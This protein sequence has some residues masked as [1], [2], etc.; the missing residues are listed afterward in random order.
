M[1]DDDGS[2][3]DS[4]S[5]PPAVNIAL[6]RAIDFVWRLGAEYP[7]TQLVPA[8][9]HAR[10]YMLQFV[11]LWTSSVLPAVISG[12]KVNE[13]DLVTLAKWLKWQRHANQR[14]GPFWLG[15]R[16]ALP[17]VVVA[18]FV[19]ELLFDGR[20]PDS[21][22]CAALAAWLAAIQASLLIVA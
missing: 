20:M 5:L 12:T 10:I 7:E 19:D 17:E 13:N 21:P 4:F 16:I 18:P 9:D 1:D 6:D 22:E 8:G 14:K 3:S 11:G 2:D 15:R